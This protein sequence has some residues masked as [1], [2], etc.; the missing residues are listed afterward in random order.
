MKILLADDER[1]VRLGLINMLDE[2]Y[3]GAHTYEQ[4][5]NGRDM[6]EIAQWFRADVA[7]VDIKM[8]LM[9]GL[10]ALERCK[11][12]CP[13]S[14]YIILSGYSDFE[15]ARA[16]LRLGAQEY[17]LKPVSLD[18]LGRVM[19]GVCAEQA[20]RRRQRGA[21]FA[22]D[23]VSA[24]HNGRA[25]IPETALDAP[26]WLALIYADHPEKLVREA[27]LSEL[28]EALR[29]EHEGKLLSE[30]RMA[31][32]MGGRGEL[33]LVTDKESA[34]LTQRIQA[35]LSGALT[36]V[37]AQDPCAEGLYARY[38]ALDQIARIRAVQGCGTLMRADAA[39]QRRAVAL[40]PLTAALCALVE[41][42]YRKDEMGYRQALN[43]L[44]N[45]FAARELF[46]QTGKRELGQ[47]L[48]AATGHEPQTASFP[49]FLDSLGRR[50]ERMYQG[51]SA[52]PVD[53]I[54]WATQYIRQNY[55]KDIGVNTLAALLSISPNYF[56]KRFHE[57]VG[58]KFIDY[59]TGVR[60][61]NA[62]RILA[63]NPRARVQETAEQVG[64]LSVRHFTKTFAKLV[65]CLPSEYQ[66]T[67]K[68]RET[69]E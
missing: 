27:L 60:I 55:M 36:C 51:A 39:L 35:R 43:L 15:Y 42:F 41:A 65:G 63:G 48:Q 33:C 7:F 40:A 22:C 64:Y 34:A 29:R 8:P 9:D 37:Q 30:L 67:L 61:Q 68:W 54:E 6:L 32:F 5:K 38:L 20:E 16:A 46:E 58:L 3:P 45:D 25:G 14:Q 4:A 23:V 11:A 57:Q 49:A 19:R 24:Y 44:E 47:F 18:T 2:L 12:L 59:L 52:G 28:M 21:R 26:L 62:K 56:S 1:M 50:A 66:A 31:L 17:L 13:D 53:E 10:T 69:N